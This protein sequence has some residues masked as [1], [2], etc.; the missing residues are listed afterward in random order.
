MDFMLSE[1]QKML[2]AMVK[3]FARKEVEPRWQEM[4]EKRRIPDDML[5]KLANLGLLGMTVPAEYN[6]T[7]HGRLCAPAGD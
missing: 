1:K 4:E 6:G 7:R 3:D 2:Q 5:K